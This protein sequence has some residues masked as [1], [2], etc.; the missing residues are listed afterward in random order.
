MDE[1]ECG[2]EESRCFKCDKEI[3]SA[4][5]DTS[6]WDMAYGAVIMSGG[7]SFGSAIYDSFYDGI[8]VRILVCDDCLQKH[9]NKIKEIDRGEGI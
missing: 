2:K 5:K 7:G 3:E 8:S 6:P 9:K 1:S 4:G